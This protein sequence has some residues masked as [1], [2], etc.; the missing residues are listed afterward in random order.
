MYA[1]VAPVLLLRFVA[2]SA[3]PNTLVFRVFGYSVAVGALRFL[4]HPTPDTMESHDHEPDFST[5]DDSPTIVQR[6]VKISV[7]KKVC[8]TSC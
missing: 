1:G 3:I 8:C 6:Y 4:G 5:A 2:E 7:Q